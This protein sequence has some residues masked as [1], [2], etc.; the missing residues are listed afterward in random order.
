MV[1]LQEEETAKI[2]RVI[3]ERAGPFSILARVPRIRG[4][5]STG[6]IL[7]VSQFQGNGRRE[8]LRSA[9]FSGQTNLLAVG[10]NATTLVLYLN[11]AEVERMPIVLTPGEQTTLQP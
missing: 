9:I 7:S 8:G 4:R 2:R 6:T 1:L 3:S 11:G 10:D 5:C